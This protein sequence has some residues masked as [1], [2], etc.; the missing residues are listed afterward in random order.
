[1]DKLDFKNKV[2]LWLKQNGFNIP[3]K[4]IRVYTY[5]GEKEVR[6]YSEPITVMNQRKSFRERK[7][8]RDDRRHG[9]YG[10]HEKT[11]SNYVHINE[12]DFENKEEIEFIKEMITNQFYEN[13]R[14]SQR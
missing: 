6:I 12:K 9:S 4:K 3:D 13:N 11:Y 8:E 7:E 5:R 10:I 1:M 14:S 2:I